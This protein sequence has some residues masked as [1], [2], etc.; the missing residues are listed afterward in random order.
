MD[1]ERSKALPAL[2]AVEEDGVYLHGSA[3][4]IPAAKERLDELLGHGPD[5]GCTEL[6]LRTYHRVHLFQTQQ[7]L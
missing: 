6:S 5:Q 4:Q 3:D 7:M 1:G 2:P